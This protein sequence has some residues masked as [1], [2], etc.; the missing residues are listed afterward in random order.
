MAGLKRSG[1]A[2]KVYAPPAPAPVRPLENGYRDDRAMGTYATI[3][4][5]NGGRPKEPRIEIPRL[6]AL[7]RG[8][9]CLLRC[10]STCD[11][12]GA[13]TVAC[14]SNLGKHGKALAMKAHDPYTVWGCARCHDA[15][16]SSRRADAIERQ[17]WFLIGLNRQIVAWRHMLKDDKT[18]PLDRAAIKAALTFLNE[19]G[20]V[21]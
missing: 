9:P 17:A 2:R 19:R 11:G 16:D 5:S 20:D 4:W 10:C 7:A 3:P 1:F 13:T 12:G 14:H 18:D 21:A 8:R 15:L 6:L